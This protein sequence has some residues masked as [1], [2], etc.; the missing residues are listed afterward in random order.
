[1][2][3]T[4]EQATKIAQMMLHAA[5][6]EGPFLVLHP[7]VT[8]RDGREDILTSIAQAL[9]EL[10][11]IGAD[12]LHGLLRFS[13]GNNDMEIDGLGEER[14]GELQK[15]WQTAPIYKDAKDRQYVMYEG[16]YTQ[17]YCYQKIDVRRYAGF[18][19][20]GSHRN[21]FKLR[22]KL[23]CN[24]DMMELEALEDSGAIDEMTDEEYLSIAHLYH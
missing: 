9:E 3:I 7:I 10:I 17:D 20:T 2:N 18:E 4:H 24:S 16:V 13:N 8:P 19:A 14:V 15:Q 1:M 6:Y 21:I 22:S 23:Q 5:T 11:G 12:V